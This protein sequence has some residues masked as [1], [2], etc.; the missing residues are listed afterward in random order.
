[1]QLAVAAHDRHWHWSDL[2]RAA[3]RRQLHLVRIDLRQLQVQLAS[4]RNASRFQ[5]NGLE[6]SEFPGLLILGIP[7]GSLEQVV[8]R[9]DALAMLQQV[10]TKIW[11][12]PRAIETCVDKYLTLE[13]LRSA[14]LPVPQTHVC[15]TAEEAFAAAES[16]GGQVIL[17]PLFGS[18]GKGLERPRNSEELRNLVTHWLQAGRILYLQEFIDHPGWDLRLLLIGDRAWSMRRSNP[19][20]WRTNASRGATV[21]PWLAT[22][23]E[24]SL[25]RRAAQA[26]GA[27]VAGV[28]L[29]YGKN[30]KPYLLEVNSAPGWKFLSAATG[31]DIAGELLDY[32]RLCL[33]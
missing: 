32:C 5:T 19:D 12:P 2:C 8:F 30:G 18:E 6:L 33:D 1:M 9:M 29:L 22:P 24:L 20:D 14:G 17:K 3:A 21:S 16:L 23:D 25:A 15:Q 26:V 7:G 27:V 4:D 13:R 10:G 31:V 11:N 28:D